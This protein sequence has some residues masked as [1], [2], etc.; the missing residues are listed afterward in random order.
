MLFIDKFLDLSE[1]QCIIDNNNTYTYSDLVKSINSNYEILQK[2]N[3][4][5]GELVALVGDYSFNSIS[6]FLALCKNKNILIPITSKNTQEINDRIQE[7]KP[8]WVY[9]LNIQSFNKFENNF[10]INRHDLINKVVSDNCAGLILFSSGTTGKPK[11]M[12]H[13]LSNLI[14]TY[15]NKKQKKII[16]LVFLMFDHI[17]GL[18]TL[19]NCLAMGSTIVIPENRTPQHVCHLIE[20]YKINV[21]PSSPTFLN[22]ILISKEYVN[23]NLLSLKLITYGTEAMPDSLLIKLKDVFPNVKFLQTFGTSETG[24]AKT[25]SK[26]STSTFI[27]IEDADQEYKIVNNELWIRSKT[28]ILGYINHNNDSFT[29]D[30]WFKTGDLVEEMEDNYIKIKGRI[31]EIINVGGEKVTPSEVE[32]VILELQEISDCVVVGEKNSITGQMVVAKVV[33][34]DGYDELDVKKSIKKHCKE[35]LEKYK[36]PSKILLTRQI[37]FSERFKKDRFNKDQ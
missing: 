18:N 23:Y 20:K 29:T 21:L 7:S 19:F 15:L 12:I 24:I 6:F 13:D 33:L 5:P 11:A 30:G 35:R 22:L 8:E 2:N 1:N 4:K 17:G 3:V 14:S 25:T 16:F 34:N 32:S 26:S 9:H 28:Q 37:E 10:N 36:I 31:K 27:K